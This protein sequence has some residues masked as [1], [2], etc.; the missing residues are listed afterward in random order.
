MALAVIAML[1]VF[2]VVLQ[3]PTVQGWTEVDAR[4]SSLAYT[5]SAARGRANRL[6]R[7]YEMSR[8]TDSLR[9]PTSRPE[10]R[11]VRVSYAP[12]ID[13]D[14]RALIDSTI[15]RGRE[16]IGD[17]LRIGVDIAV[18]YDTSSS[19]R[20]AARNQFATSEFYSL[21][22]A[23]GQR[24]L[25]VLQ[26]GRDR[27]NSSR[28]TLRSE[29]ASEQV[30]GPC[31]YYAVF[32]IP[33]PAVRTWLQ[34]SG[35]TLALGG[36]WT[37]LSERTPSRMRRDPYFDAR[38][39]AL[40]NLSIRGSRCAAGDVGVCEEIGLQ[41]NPYQRSL[42]VGSIVSPSDRMGATRWVPADLGGR[43]TEML[44]G[45]VRSLGREKFAAFWTSSDPVPVAFERASGVSLGAWTAS[46]LTEQFGE[47]RRGPGT[48]AIS[49]VSAALIVGIAIF[50]AV[51]A[52]R[53]R[54]FA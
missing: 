29:V 53:R 48:S 28:R 36:S 8:I 3:E 27:G 46:W 49:I 44:A 42:S 12:E 16:R 7:L 50:F 13:P 4:E 25:S 37:R 24:C 17:S 45:M 11:R 54:E 5:A 39:P 26:I 40:E 19:V 10:S 21:P 31:A 6:G 32:G 2:I 43:E 15:A 41:P 22:S 47:L 34:Q 30:F 14:L 9:G 1:A 52:A 33:G 20:G 51:R 35:A 38:H 23:P 18:I